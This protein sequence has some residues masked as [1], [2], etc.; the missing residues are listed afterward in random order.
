M[1][2]NLKQIIALVLVLTIRG[3]CATDITSQAFGGINDTIISAF[4]DFDSDELTDVFVRSTDGR[5]LEILLASDQEPLLRR[6]PNTICRFK[7]LNITSIVPGD[8]DGDA[9]MDLLITS[10]SNRSNDL[11]DVYINWG[12]SDILNCTDENEEPLLQMIGEPVAL[13]YNS[14]MIIDLFGLN[15]Q[16]QRTFWIFKKS[17]EKPQEIQMEIPADEHLS[18]L[19]VPHSHAYLDLNNDFRADL[20]LVTE[21][22]FEV[23]HGNDVGFNYSETRVPTVIDNAVYG[24]SIFLDIE[25]N[26]NIAQVLPICFDQRCQSSAILAYVNGKYFNLDISFTDDKNQMWQFIHPKSKQHSVY[27]NSIT[28]RGGDFNLDGYP[29]M[30]VTLQ[31]ATNTSKIQTF[32]MENV[33][34]NHCGQ[35]TRS[36]AIQWGAFAGSA[37]GT[38]VG[39]FYD[40][41]QVS[42]TFGHFHQKIHFNESNRSFRSLSGWYFG[43]NFCEEAS[44]WHFKSGGVPEFTRL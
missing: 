22:G 8:F 2:S 27:Q 26:E 43:C 3:I 38:V 37:D 18:H 29:D 12:G 40:F 39:A 20:F 25:L 35:L 11:L 31:S 7:R 1:N 23:W 15:E 5:T 41:Y 36:F 44:K 13:D 42:W 34:C 16:K 33:E 21:N 6:S 10:K 4:G 19:K 14:D 9:F 32:L 17:H 28:L 24:Q 30:L